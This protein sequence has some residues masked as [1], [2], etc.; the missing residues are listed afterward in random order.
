MRIGFDA[1]RA[2]NNGSGLGNY[3]RNLLNALMRDYTGNDYLLFASKTKEEFLN[4]LDGNFKLIFPETKLQRS[5]HP[6]WRTFSIKKQLLKNRISVYHGL[7]NELPYGISYTGIPT[8]VTIHD[9]IFLKDKEQYPYLDRM[10]YKA[11]TQYAAKVA[12]KIIAVSSE[13]KK[14]IVE[15]YGVDEKKVFVIPPPIAG[16]FQTTINQEER[17]ST[18]KKYNLPGKY[19]LHVGSFF[20]RK[21]QKAV[22]EAF[23]LVKNKLEEDLILVGGAGNMLDEINALISSRGL[24]GRV[25][26]LTGVSNEDMPAIYQSASLLVF[27]A[28]YEGFGMPVA[29]ALFS[30]LP[31]ITT[32]GGSMEEAGGK[33]AIYVDPLSPDE[34][35]RA[36]LKILSDFQLRESMIETGWAH[37]QT[38]TDKT[39]AGKT[40]QVYQS[41]R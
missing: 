6:I 41:I 33:S 18:I 36:I 26:I 9:L 29:E 17:A 19:L 31:V 30:R 37:A 3:S 39:V 15:L 4:S 8:V 24:Q 13:T 14:D 20:P 2:L 21:N 40:M 34:I 35:A 25:K 32:G 5:A 12:D 27:P 7:S 28:L 38:M 1:K 16:E 23:D 11:K 22:V 10:M